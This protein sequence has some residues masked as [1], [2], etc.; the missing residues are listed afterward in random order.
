MTITKAFA[1]LSPVPEVHLL[2]GLETCDLQGQVAF[3]SNAWELFRQVDEMRRGQEVEVF[4]YP[5]MADSQKPLQMKATWHA[6][7][8]CHI[9]SRRGRYPGDKR[10]RPE[11]AVHDKPDWAIF[12][13]VC[14]LTQLPEA[15]Q[16][17]LGDFRGW[18]KKTDYALRSVPTVP[19]LVKYPL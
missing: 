19:V 11:S 14:E 1:I 6:L 2:S 8:V 9:L 13:E 18:D 4:I 5:T 3:G 12:W 15:E 7:Y 17:S 16:I 10:F